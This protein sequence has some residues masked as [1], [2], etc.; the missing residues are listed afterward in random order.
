M[1]SRAVAVDEANV[2]PL[3]MDHR[4]AWVVMT[5]SFLALMIESG[6]R[7][8]LGVY[9]LHFLNTFNCTKSQVASVYGAINASC[10]I[11]GP[12]AGIFYK[13]FGA[14]AAVMIGGLLAA[15]GYFLIVFTSTIYQV[16]VLGIAIGVGSGLIRTATVSVQPEY[17]LKYRN[18]AMG[19]VFIGPGLGIFIF[20]H[21][22]GYLV[23]HF[24][25][26]GSLVFVSALVLQCVVLGALLKPRR[27]RQSHH[28]GLKDF[29]A[30]T[31]W[32]NPLFVL[33]GMGMFLAAGCCFI[34]FA[35]DITL[36]Q[37]RGLSE[38]EALF[39]FSM[40]G[41]FS[42]LGRFVAIAVVQ[43]EDMNI[44]IFMAL[45]YLTAQIPMF[46]GVFCYN[47]IMFTIQN[48]L[49]GFGN[50][51]FPVALAPFLIYIGGVENLPVALG[52]SNFLNGIG[53]LA[54]LEVG[55]K[56]TPYEYDMFHFPDRVI[57]TRYTHM[58]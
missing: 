21:V 46:S 20:P 48:S 26:R 58:C 49:T 57:I 34:Y 28:A 36:M 39:T 2:P 5:A 22:I 24:A 15:T 29:M 27:H 37:H 8:S 11:S 53:G 41:I 3:K 44:T 33:Q 1:T 54:I 31:L 17:F 19:V 52:Y 45:C 47:R 30:L 25:W 9:F 42:L 38:E 32:K 18:L 4:R 43:W 51:L 56:R 10:F 12:I 14:R 23:E 40:H 16:I 6:L 35:F 50:G 13:M 55:G 7:P